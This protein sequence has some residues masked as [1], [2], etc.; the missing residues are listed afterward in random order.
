MDFG[1][2]SSSKAVTVISHFI[3][4]TVHASMLFFNTLKSCYNSEI[5]F[6]LLF[7]TDYVHAT[8]CSL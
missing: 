4:C 3:K 1:N 7:K 8:E 5:P 6:K 2:L